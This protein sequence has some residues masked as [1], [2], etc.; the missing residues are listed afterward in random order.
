MIKIEVDLDEEFAAQSKK[1]KQIV[2]LAQ[3]P[4]N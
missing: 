1:Q 3:S 4:K 2:S